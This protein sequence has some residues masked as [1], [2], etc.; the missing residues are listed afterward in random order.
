MEQIHRKKAK[1][2]YWGQG[3]T[4][5]KGVKVYTQDEIIALNSFLKRRE[6]L[7]ETRRPLWLRNAFYV[8]RTQ[9]GLDWMAR[10]EDNNYRLMFCLESWK[11]FNW[12]NHQN[13][14]FRKKQ[15]RLTFKDYMKG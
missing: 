1:G 12:G 3:I 9:E 5:S 11:R 6:S 2:R 14:P 7:P 15:S 13:E 10:K 4:S 8:F